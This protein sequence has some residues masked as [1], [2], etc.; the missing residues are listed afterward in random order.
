L[1]VVA[2]TQGVHV[3]AARHSFW[4]LLVSRL[5]LGIPLLIGLALT[6]KFLLEVLLLNLARRRFFPA[7][8]AASQ[9]TGNVRSG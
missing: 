4:C 3:R 7:D 2:L 6:G 9:I 8:R 1:G 5:L